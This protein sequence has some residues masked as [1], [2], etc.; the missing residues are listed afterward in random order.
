[1]RIYLDTSVINAYL[2][3]KHSTIEAD[4]F[5]ATNKL[6]GLINAKRITAVVSLYSI[7]E[8]FSFCKNFSPRM[9]AASQE[10]PYPA[11]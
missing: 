2:F 9:R 5:T 4:R 10:S 11:S 8:I 3:G 1:L 6:F 7:Q